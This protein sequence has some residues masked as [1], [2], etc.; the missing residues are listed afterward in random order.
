MESSAGDAVAGV[1]GDGIGYDNADRVVSSAARA[2]TP[3]GEM[4]QL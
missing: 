3:Q 2:P 4:E 1:D